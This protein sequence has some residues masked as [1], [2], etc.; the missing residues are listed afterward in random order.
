M[1]EARPFS[2]SAS[3][4]VGPFYAYALTPNGKL[5]CLW[6]P[7]VEGEHM[8][9][10][11]FVSDGERAPVIDAMVEIWQADAQGRYS[12]PDDPQGREADPAFCGFGRVSTDEHGVCVFDTVRP[13]ASGDQATH[14]NITIFARG[15]LN[16]LCT[17]LYFAGDPRLESDPVLSIV[18]AE[19]RHTLIAKRDAGDSAQWNLD[20]CLQGD[21]ETVF[22]AI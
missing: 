21:D 15:L 14:I 19:R 7:E 16:H 10:R 1:N 20:I 3:Q 2:P 11:L 22:F 8:R 9:V 12:H 13:G 17:R 18:P 6:T 5:G 4:T